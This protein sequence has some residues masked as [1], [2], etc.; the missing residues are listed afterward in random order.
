MK[1]LA[2]L[3]VLL[4]SSLARAQLPF[5]TD[6]VAPQRFVAVHGEKAVV[7]GYASDG[8]ELW[9]YPLQLI[10]DYDVR[11]SPRRADHGSQRVGVAAANHL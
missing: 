5:D 11:F 8:L 9:T 7:M 6:S 10:S 2:C 3:I 1:L 4:Y